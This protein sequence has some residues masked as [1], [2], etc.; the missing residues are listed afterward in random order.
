MSR[1]KEWYYKSNTTLSA[2]R[3]DTLL[4]STG[5]TSAWWDNFIYEV[6]GP[7]DGGKTLECQE[8]TSWN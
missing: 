1:D 2:L 8:R 3:E 5:R 6:V 4:D 7:D